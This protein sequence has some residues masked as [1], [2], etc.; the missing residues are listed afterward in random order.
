MSVVQKKISVNASCE[1]VWKYLTDP[2]LLAAWLMR[3]NFSG[4]VGKDFQFRAQPNK[5]WDGILRCRLVEL[6]APKKIAFTWNANDIGGETLVTIELTEKGDQTHVRLIHANFENASLDIQPIIERHAVGWDDHLG[7]LAAQINEEAVGARKHPDT[8]DWTQFDL[9][10]AI[11]ADPTDVIDAWST[12]NGME[13]FFVQLMRITDLNGSELDPAIPAKPGDQFIWR[14]HSG[15]RVQGKYLPTDK[16]N[17]VA[18][19]FGESNIMI[20]TRPYRAGTLLRLR[21]FDIPDTE[22]AHMHI[23][24][25]C[26][27]AWVYFLT[28]L[29][30]VL[31]DGYD[32]RDH[33]R[34]TGGIFS[35]YFDP[36]DLGVDFG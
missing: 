18:F 25:N 24:S 8:I 31:E 32:P 3:N 5:D 30:S 20:S 35:T 26:R 6:V 7:V 33:S 29:K 1:A 27:A 9:Y 28:T 4:Q 15:R 36:A 14:W 2:D 22:Q 21:Q 34:E 16:A 23:H 10:V 17:D 11:D 13:S 12:I 19:S